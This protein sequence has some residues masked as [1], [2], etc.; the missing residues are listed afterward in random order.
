MHRPSNV[1]N[2]QTLSGLIS[3]L[4]Q[5]STQTPLIIPAHPRT[6]NSLERF[7]ML[8]RLSN[9][10]EIHII[11]PQGYFDFINLVSNSKFVM[12]DS[13]GLQEESTILGVP[14]LTLRENTERPITVTQGTNKVV[15]TE[16]KDIIDEFQNLDFSKKPRRPEYWDGKTAHRIAEV[17]VNELRMVD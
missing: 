12:T 8:D 13:G 17:I 2:L 14:C 4:E 3:A 1:D 10:E 5:I 16:T 9:N 7:E 11:P 15:G 6:I